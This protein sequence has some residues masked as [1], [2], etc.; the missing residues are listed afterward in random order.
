MGKKKI[1]KIT[2][3]ILVILLLLTSMV[4]LATATGRL[5]AGN[6]GTNP[7]CAQTY[8]VQRGD[9]LSTIAQRLLNNL[10]AYNLIFQAT[11]AAVGTG[12]NITAVQ[13]PNLIE[14]GQVLCIP[15]SANMAP[16]GGTTTGS[17]VSDAA[18]TAQTTTPTTNPVSQAFNLTPEQGILLVENRTGGDVVFDI[19]QPVPSSAWIGPN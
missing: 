3:I 13:D 17:T 2:S 4:G 6:Q 16:V 9:S 18:S 10:L 7:A 12:S 14:P 8:G 1:I 15:A 11:N 5:Q 19:T